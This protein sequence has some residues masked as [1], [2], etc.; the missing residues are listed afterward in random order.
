MTVG[1]TDADTDDCK[2]AGGRATQDAKAELTGKYLQRV[3]G[4][5]YSLLPSVSVLNPDTS[6]QPL[7]A[8]IPAPERD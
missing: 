8:G 7:T 4:E 5:E 6:V 1:G 2:D 3:M